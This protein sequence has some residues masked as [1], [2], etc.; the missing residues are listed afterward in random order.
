MTWVGLLEFILSIMSLFS[1]TLY[2][3]LAKYTKPGLPFVL[4]NDVSMPGIKLA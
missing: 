2:T 4:K 1:S 3:K